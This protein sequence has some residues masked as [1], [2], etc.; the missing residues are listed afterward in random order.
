MSHR[1]RFAAAA[2]GVATAGTLGGCASARPDVGPA[3]VDYAS[4]AAWLCRPGR[5]D[6]CA[7]DV[8]ATVVAADGTLTFVPSPPAT[9]SAIDCFYVYPT[10]SLDPGDNSDMTPGP[11]EVRTTVAQFAPFRSVCRPFAPLYRQMTLT[12]LRRAAVTGGERRGADL[13]YGDVRAAF[14]R[15][16]A[17]DNGGR[18][19]VLIGHSQGAAMLKRLV[20]DEID[21][22]PVAG[23]MVLAMLIGSNVEVPVGAEV[24]GDFRSTP[25]CRSASQTG[26][27][28][29]YESFR[30][31]RPVPADSRFGRTAAPGREVGCTNPAAL[32]GGEAVLDARLPATG[33]GQSASTQ[34]PWV[35]GGSPIATPFVRVPGLLSAACRTID[36]ANV[37]AIATHGDPADPRADTIGGDVLAG[38]ATLAGWGLHLT[39]MNVAQGDLIALVARHAAAPR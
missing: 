34:E 36:G 21:G 17:H 25:L 4:A 32:A 29:T 14:A 30:A 6:A 19:F 16:L 7:R 3:A 20:A 24:G 12:G 8:S 31:D 38:G 23:R 26:C 33:F 11:E 39:D 2:L 15:Y 9:T 1:W 35:R 37:L 5:D 18:P 28:V 27:V 13:A 22:R 10:A